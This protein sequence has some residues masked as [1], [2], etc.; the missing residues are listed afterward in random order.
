M[1]FGERERERE[2]CIAHSLTS[3]SGGY[4]GLAAIWEEER[5]RRQLLGLETVLTPPP[6]PGVKWEGGREEGRDGGSE[7]WRE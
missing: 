1:V 6:S 5:N 3:A 7:G 2:R 4:P